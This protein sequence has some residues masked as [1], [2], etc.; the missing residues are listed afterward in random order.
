MSIKPS[1]IEISFEPDAVI[2]V[3]S[4]Q[5]EQS[6]EALLQRTMIVSRSLLGP[7]DDE[8]QDIALRIIDFAHEAI[9]EHQYS[10]SD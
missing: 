7:L 2:I 9:K 6:P 5:F 3:H 10:E 4:E 1:I 8:L